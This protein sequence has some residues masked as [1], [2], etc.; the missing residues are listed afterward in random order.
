MLF[1]SSRI[2]VRGKDIN[3]MDVTIDSL[4]GKKMDEVTVKLQ[5]NGIVDSYSLFVKIEE[6]LGVT[7]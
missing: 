5:E 1:R 4:N 2:R 7:I 6:L 3:K